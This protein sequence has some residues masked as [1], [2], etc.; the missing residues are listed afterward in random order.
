[1]ATYSLGYRDFRRVCRV[2]RR[3]LSATGVLDNES[4]RGVLINKLEPAHPAAAAA[5]RRLTSWE[6]EKLLQNVERHLAGP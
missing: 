6:L 1:M 5:L 4:I 2:Y 3:L